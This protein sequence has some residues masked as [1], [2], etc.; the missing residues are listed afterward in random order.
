MEF[1]L[2][3]AGTYDRFVNNLS[4]M[5]RTPR[6]VVI[7]SIFGRFNGGST[8]EIQRVDG[9]REMNHVGTGIGTRIRD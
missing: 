3:R 2:E 4:G 8:S 7:R 1:Y 5:P 9:D 6:A